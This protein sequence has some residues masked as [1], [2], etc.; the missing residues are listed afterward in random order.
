MSLWI[1]LYRTDKEKDFPL[2]KVDTCEKMGISED[3]YHSGV[4]ELVEKRYLIEN[5][6]GHYNFYAIPR[7]F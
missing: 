3:N 4:K 1:Y 7:R 6:K 2:N 5:G